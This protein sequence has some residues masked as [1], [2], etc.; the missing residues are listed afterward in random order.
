MKLEDIANLLAEKINQSH[1][2][3]HYLNKVFS[4]GFELGEKEKENFAIGF[5]E[6]KDKI[7]D[8]DLRYS[9]KYA[10]SNEQLL[11]IYKETL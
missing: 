8:S 7:S 2:I 4:K 3:L 11:E 9:A 6:W 10:K 5:V 1:Y